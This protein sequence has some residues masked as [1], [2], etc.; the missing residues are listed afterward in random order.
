[1]QCIL[2]FLPIAKQLTALFSVE[3]MSVMFYSKK[4]TFGEKNLL[5]AKKTSKHISLNIDL[6]IAI[7]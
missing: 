1:L 2:G 3:D 5:L 7:P 4:G 6:Q